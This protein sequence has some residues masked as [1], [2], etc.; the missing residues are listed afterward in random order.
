[1]HILFFIDSEDKK[2]YS[3]LLQNVKRETS[4]IMTLDIK[5]F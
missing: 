5:I 2:G 1:M 3:T 4:K